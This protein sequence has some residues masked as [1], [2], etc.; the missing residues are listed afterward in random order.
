MHFQKTN[1]KVNRG[2]EHRVGKNMY[3]SH[4]KS[5]SSSLIN[6]EKQIESSVSYFLSSELAK[7]EIFKV[8]K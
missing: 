4:V 2:H 3:V 1:R 7:D 5:Y 8:V 6:K